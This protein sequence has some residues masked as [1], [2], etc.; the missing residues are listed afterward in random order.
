MNQSELMLR[1]ISLAEQA[2]GKTFPNPCV[3]A[4][5]AAGDEI[6]GQ[7]FHRAYG[8]KHA[9]VEAIDDAFSR[10]HDLSRCTMYVTLEPCNHHGK[11]PPCTRAILES[12][13]RE[14]VIGAMDPNTSV[15]G[16]GADFLRQSGVRVKTG[17]EEQQCLDLIADFRVWQQ[18][19]RSYLYLK[20]ASTL[21][22]RIATREHHSRWVTSDASLRKVHYLRSIVGAVIIG[23]NTLY[24]DNPRLTCRGYE[25]ERQPLR[26]V[27]TSRLPEPDSDLH[28]LRQTPDQTMF[29]TGHEASSSS[30]AQRLRDMGC[31]VMALDRTDAGLDL[32][33]GLTR[34]RQEKNIHYAMC[35][36]GGRMGLSFI[37]AGLVDEMWC[38]T[39]MRVLGDEL[40]VPVF[41]GRSTKLMSE[42]FDFRL[43][44]SRVVGRDLWLRLF[45]GIDTD[46]RQT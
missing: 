33:L 21:D 30:E 23:G 43:S 1:A 19:P 28:L 10:G 46:P 16:G 35:E 14:V 25:V 44:G 6:V 7:G 36:G 20:T 24:Q 2:K 41:H 42:A 9:E 39:A 31:Q 5:V 13:I 37:Q 3:G 38:F 4:L 11:T 17:I 15:A 22:G 18:T 8:S 27:V 26:I 40:G 34:L 12:G 32:S 45:P 29:W